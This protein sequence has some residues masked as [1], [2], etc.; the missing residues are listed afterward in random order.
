MTENDIVMTE[1]YIIKLCYFCDYPYEVPANY[2]VN[3]DE[4]GNYNMGFINK[5]NDLWVCYTCS[6][7]KFSKINFRIQENGECCVCYEDKTL[8]KLPTCV[9]KLCIKCCK[10]IY[11]GSTDIEPPTISRNDVERPVWPY[12]F[13]S[14]NE[15]E[16]KGTRKDWMIWD[17]KE[18]EYS[19]FINK[20][21]NEYYKSYDEIIALRDSLIL[22]KVE[23]RLDWMNTEKFIN[24]ENERFCY[25]IVLKKIEKKWQKF[26][27]KKTKGNALCPICRAKP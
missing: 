25:D 11:Y 18:G 22:E 19:D 26:N 7:D 10:T 2:A 16:F 23:E 17:D 6:I 1:N 5:F 13:Y 8:L 15:E 27:D 24:Y 3:I 12:P 14:S 21:F 20:Y 9:H 4:N